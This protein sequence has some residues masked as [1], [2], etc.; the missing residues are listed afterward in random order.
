MGFQRKL[1]EIT[2]EGYL[3]GLEVRSR[4][5]SMDQLLTFVAFQEFDLS[6]GEASSALWKRVC[7]TLA[8]CMVSWNLEDEIGRPVPL[9]TDAIAGQ[10]FDLVMEITGAIGSRATKPDADL[11]KGSSSTGSSVEASLPMAPLS[12]DLAS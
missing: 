1:I 4:P 10:G 11:G 6:D 8:E 12:D 7:Q 2:F 3:S 9:T 5:I